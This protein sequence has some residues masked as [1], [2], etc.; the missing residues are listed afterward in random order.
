VRGSY[1]TSGTAA[2]AWYGSLAAYMNRALG[3]A[4]EATRFGPGAV[5][6]VALLDEAADSLALLRHLG[7]TCPVPES[8]AAARRPALIVHAAR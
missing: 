2:A 5:G 3:L 6:E 8:V 1:G 7:E 4:S